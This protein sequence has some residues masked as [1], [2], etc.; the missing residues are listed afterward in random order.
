MAIRQTRAG[1]NID[2]KH[3][4]NR[5]RAIDVACDMNAKGHLILDDY[6]TGYSICQQLAVRAPKTIRAHRRY[7]NKRDGDLHQA[8][9]GDSP[10][11]KLLG[12]QFAQFLKQT[13]VDHGA[14][15]NT[16]EQVFCEPDVHGQE[17]ILKNLWLAEC[18]EEGAKLNL[19]FVL[20]NAQE[21]SIWQS[22][23]DAGYY[24]PLLNVVAK[25][26]KNRIGIHSYWL[27]TAQGNISNAAIAKL[28]TPGAF[29]Y[30]SWKITADNI[31]AQ[32]AAFI[33][34]WRQSHLCSGTMALTRRAV[35]V[36][37]IP[38]PKFI[39]TEYGP[40]LVRL[41]KD[42]AITEAVKAMNGGEDPMGYP[43]LDVYYETMFKAEGWTKAQ[44]L[45]E[46]VKWL[47]VVEMPEVEFFCL[48]GLDTSYEGGRYHVG[49]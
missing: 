32:C 5:Q 42:G 2:A 47:D 9:N 15:P 8:D 19:A 35:D 13:Q 1:L 17:L 12:K 14:P 3:P 11:G 46:Q 21:F 16:L 6:L 10:T 39:K 24:D 37:K 18:A 43:T 48:F 45:M 49:D 33:A 22:E 4:G 28:A 38:A 20:D 36:L 26:P 25:H 44:A 41:F 23:V 30:K 29:P 7:M 34:N 40:D 31:E 27:G